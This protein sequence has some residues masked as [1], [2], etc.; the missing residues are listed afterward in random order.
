MTSAEVT[1]LTTDQ[2]TALKTGQ[3]AARQGQIAARQIAARASGTNPERQLPD[4]T[5]Y[6][7]SRPE[8]RELTRIETSYRFRGDGVIQ[9]TVRQQHDPQA[10]DEDLDWARRQFG[11]LI[12]A[13]G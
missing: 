13:P 1:A 7:L 6:V 11:E 10:G 3:I 8:P 2:V 12:A 5:C 9:Q 4:S